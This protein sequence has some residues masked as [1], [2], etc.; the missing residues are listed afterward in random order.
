MARGGKREGAGRP[1][2]AA[3]KATTEVREAAQ[4]HTTAAVETLASIMKTSES[5][6]ARIAAAN[7][8]LD[9]AVGKPTQ[10]V[11]GDIELRATVTKIIL[12]GPDGDG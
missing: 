10:T 9:R 8:I 6:T 7:S 1:P 2:G 5:D 4:L 12:A 11:E 3:N